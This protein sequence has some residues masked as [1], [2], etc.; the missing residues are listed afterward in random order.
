MKL[1]FYQLLDIVEKNYIHMNNY[2]FVKYGNNRKCNIIKNLSKS[3]IACNLQ[4][5]RKY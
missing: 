5:T 1:S 3:P 4:I 2:Y